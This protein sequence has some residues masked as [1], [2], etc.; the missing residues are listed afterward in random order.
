MGKLE[1]SL[2]LPSLPEQLIKISTDYKQFISF[3][4]SQIKSIKILESTELETITEE[5]LVFSTY[6]N[7]KIIQKSSHKKISPNQLLTSIISGPFKDSK[8]NVNFESIETGSKVSVLLDL[9]VSLKYKLLEP[10]IK[11]RYKTVFTGLLYKMNNVIQN[12]N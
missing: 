4:E 3:F 10:I 7:H 12:Q 5:T 2:N 9:H 8:I 11:R 1:F 6:I